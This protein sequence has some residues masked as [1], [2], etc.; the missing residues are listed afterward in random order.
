MPSFSLRKL[1]SR[2]NSR[3]RLKND[4]GGSSGGGGGS[5]STSKQQPQAAAAVVSP[6]GL[7]FLGSKQGPNNYPTYDMSSGAT[8]PPPNKRIGRQISNGSAD[9]MAYSSN[10]SEASDGVF[11]TAFD[12][13]PPTFSDDVLDRGIFPTPP[14]DIIVGGASYSRTWEADHDLAV[15]E[16]MTNE[17]TMFS[18]PSFENRNPMTVTKNMGALQR[19]DPKN[20]HHQ[21]V[22]DN[23]FGAMPKEKIARLVSPDRNTTPA[24]TS[25]AAAPAAI[26]AAHNDD[27][28]A[29]GLTS[30]A[31]TT[32][33]T[34]MDNRESQTTNRATTMTHDTDNL[35][36][37]FGSNFFSSGF[38]D[39][40]G[41]FGQSDWAEVSSSKSPTNDNMSGA[42]G[43]DVKA[44]YPWGQTQGGV[45]PFEEKKDE[46]TGSVVF[47]NVSLPDPI[48]PTTEP[49]FSHPL[50]QQQLQQ[51]QMKTNKEVVVSFEDYNHEIMHSPSN[52]S[53]SSRPT[54]VER[55]TS[56]E[57]SSRPPV[58]TSKS[59]RRINSNGSGSRRRGGKSGGSV[60]SNSSA[61]D[62]I[63][64]HYRQ[65]RL[66]KHHG[67]KTSSAAS[68]TVS[69]QPSSSNHRSTPS[70]DSI[71][72]APS[73]DMA[74]AA[75]AAAPAAAALSIIHSQNSSQLN[76]IMT[77][78]LS[79]SSGLMS[80][81]QSS[82]L[83]PKNQ[84]N[85]NRSNRVV[86][87]P[88]DD[89]VYIAAAPP[90]PSRIANETARVDDAAD[91]FLMA[92]IEATIGP[93]GSAPDI[94]SLSGRSYKSPRLRHQTSDAKSIDSWTSRNSRYSFRTYESN[95]SA[96]KGIKSMSPESKSVANDLFRLEAQLA[97]VARQQELQ[98][99]EPLSSPREVI[100]VGDS[101]TLNK[102]NSSNSDM[103]SNN[104]YIGAEPA[105]RLNP[106]TVVAPPGK[107]GILL[108]NNKAG[109]VS[110]TPTHVSAVRSESVLAGKVQV[111]D[112]LMKIDGEDVSRCNSKQ[113][114]AI[115]AGKSELE[116][117]LEFRCLESSYDP[118]EWI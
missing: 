21:N 7:K 79:S 22:M 104:G 103:S 6:E 20:H 91:Q 16:E 60:G 15:L 45:N 54:T 58:T 88:D 77:S 30:T 117:V 109:G 35:Q 90:P 114:M 74:A 98:G 40:D 61:V 29:W 69:S 73:S 42:V 110:P 28:S 24:H 84:S 52:S 2:S 102:N 116:R 41:F 59:H 83:L 85:N 86:N 34:T 66:A 9:S 39:D 118:L 97:E 56:Y 70:F 48:T 23:S 43:G 92:N 17:W 65:K 100:F 76:D 3:Q 27:L 26:T 14:A 101:N 55:N 38:D 96:L 72:S 19:D 78:A 36:D 112:Q 80:P 64:E 107:L 49:T 4:D 89:E 8:A 67:G 93:R 108:S 115:M 63:L 111:G 5:L 106:I 75:A 10:A 44:N 37:A 51:H 94:E 82:P 95:R 18:D 53:F 105:P 12:R 47:T 31:T 32:A 46:D 113:I 25:T 99:D 81:S 62:Q 57:R 87:W 68:S 11:I 71:S 33:T 13:C 50:K 1:R